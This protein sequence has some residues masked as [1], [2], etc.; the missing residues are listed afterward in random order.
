MLYC[1]FPGPP[2]QRGTI[3]RISTCFQDNPNVVPS[4]TFGELW[5]HYQGDIPSQ[6]KYR[7]ANNIMPKKNHDY[8]CNDICTYMTRCA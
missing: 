3:G 5:I 1:N 2:S 7:Y 4:N 8:R 6:H